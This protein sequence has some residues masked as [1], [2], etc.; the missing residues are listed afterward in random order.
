M[1]QKLDTDFILKI[2]DM[3]SKVPSAEVRSYIRN[4]LSVGRSRGNEI[5]SEIMSTK[6]DKSGEIVN[7]KYTFNRDTKSYEVFLRSL[8][9][10][11]FIQEDLHKAMMRAYISNT[12]VDEISIKFNFPVSAIS[13][14]KSIFGWK[15]G[16]IIITDEDVSDNSIDKCAQDLLDEKKLEVLQEFNRLNWKKTQ[17][18]ARN[19]E[20]FELGELKPFESFLSRWT[21][22]A[23]KYTSPSKK[24]RKYNLIVVLSD[25]HF[26][27]ESNPNNMFRKTGHS[28]EKTVAAI[29]DYYTRLLNDI[30]SHNYDIESVRILSLGDQI[31]SANPYSQTTKGTIVKS[32]LLGEELFE[33]AFDSINEFIYNISANVPE[34]KVTALKGNH[35]G[36]LDLILFKA[37]SVYYRD[38]KNISF[39]LIGAPATSFRER[40]TFCIASHGAHD[41]LKA[42]FT[43]GPKIQ[44]YIQSLI[45]HAQEKEKGVT[46]R[47]AFFGDLHHSEMKEYNDFTYYLCPS[48]V[49]NDEYSDALGLASR[50][51]QSAFLVDDLGINKVF[52]YYF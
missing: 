4:E 39:D 24:N 9:K 52:N 43:P 44:T 48:I 27:C 33:V 8:G 16:G 37:I 50:S 28:T 23:P 14:Y 38:Q 49:Q 45:I 30:F 41:S 51:A 6:I 31:H 47:A 17:D 7:N 20:L 26:G 32:D 15:R 18:A 35:C 22:K 19:W 1:K 3:A 2:Q 42:K 13:E 5:Y 11:V 34:T 36:Q 46:S 29:R 40:N 25:T 21:P 12:S 10:K